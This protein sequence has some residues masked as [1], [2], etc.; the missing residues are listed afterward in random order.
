MPLASTL[1]L[2]VLVSRVGLS[3]NGTA[4]AAKK[5]V[6][7]QFRSSGQNPNTQGEC[8]AFD[9]RALAATQQH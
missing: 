2:E 7:F 5:V 4:E 9:L 1:C 6:P 8:I 3:P